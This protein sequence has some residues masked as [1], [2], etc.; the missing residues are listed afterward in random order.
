[1][2]AN[3]ELSQMFR[4]MGEDYLTDIDMSGSLY[5]QY[6]ELDKPKLE[7]TATNFGKFYKAKLNGVSI[8]REKLYNILGIESTAGMRL[9]YHLFEFEKHDQKYI[10]DFSEI[11]VS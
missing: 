4:Q 5:L 2:G 7:V 6:K 1:M 3:K 10:I 9:E 11:S 8:N